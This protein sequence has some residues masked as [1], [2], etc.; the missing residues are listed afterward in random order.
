MSALTE[1]SFLPTGIAALAS[2]GAAAAPSV[3]TPCITIKSNRRPETI[4]QQRLNRATDDKTVWG[5][6]VYQECR[7]YSQGNR[8]TG[9][10]S[11]TW[12]TQWD[13]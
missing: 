5:T 9:S 6:T 7:S 3:V 2:S 4:G 1:R 12:C 11:P 13:N 8:I 10:G